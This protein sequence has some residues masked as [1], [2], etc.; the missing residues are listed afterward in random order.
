MVP[1]VD[2]LQLQLQFMPTSLGGDG[3]RV[4][5]MRDVFDK[6][7]SPRDLYQWRTSP[8]QL[9]KAQHEEAENRLLE[10][11][12]LKAG[13]TVKQIVAP[14]AADQMRQQE[15]RKMQAQRRRQVLG[16]EA[17]I[18]DDDGG[19]GWGGGALNQLVRNVGKDSQ[20]GE[21][22]TVPPVPPSNAELN[23]EKDRLQVAARRLSS[24]S[25]LTPK[26]PSPPPPQQK[27][28]RRMILHLPNAVQVR[29]FSSTCEPRLGSLSQVSRTCVVAG[30]DMAALHRYG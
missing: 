20:P 11:E 21:A 27:K 6:G 28:K 12:A 8:A 9:A 10:I 23:K 15:R 14:T 13:K 25:K 16:Y 30:A 3:G 1:A 5:M 22:W 7:V 4:E 18:D 19:R 29:A 26:P 2:M 17:A 24:L